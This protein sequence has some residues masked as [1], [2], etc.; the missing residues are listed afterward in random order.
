MNEQQLADIFSEQLDLL[1]QE[2]PVNLPAQAVDLQGLLGLGQ[3]FAQ[4]QFQPSAAAQ[5]AFQGQLATW[6]TPVS[7]IPSAATWLGIPKNLVAIM[8]IAGGGLGLAAIIGLT[9]LLN[10]NNAPATAPETPALNA[11][12][13]E[14]LNPEPKT[15]PGASPAS[16]ETGHDAGQKSQQSS[17]Q[18]PG[19]KPD[20]SAGD[21]INAP[22]PASAGDS[23]SLPTPAV[24]TSTAPI[25]PV[26]SADPAT[27]GSSSGGSGDTGSGDTGSGDNAPDP[28]DDDRGHGNDPGGY[29]P[30]NPGNSTGVGGGQDNAPNL[31]R[32]NGS[33][34]S[35]A[36]GNSGGNSSGDNSGNNSNNGKAKG[37][38]K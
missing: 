16:D 7:G 3:Q 25:T 36:G 26:I 17:D 2:Q 12:A 22:K 13:H 34:G 10:D 24:M 19:K 8:L 20:N 21:M 27:G 31:G 9:A 37:K 4:V 5:A 15:V 30:D 18:L 38:D 32:G 1:L 28:F 6:F 11:P 14:E 29:D 23:L 35:S 33:S